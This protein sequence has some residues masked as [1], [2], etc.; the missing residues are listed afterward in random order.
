MPLFDFLVCLE[1]QLINE[2]PHPVFSLLPLKRDI[3]SKPPSTLSE[4]SSTLN[5][6]RRTL[7]CVIAPHPLIILFLAS[8]T[9][10][11]LWLIFKTKIEILKVF[12]KAERI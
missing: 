11:I 12:F 3:L 4:L 10:E 1:I 8:H 6:L 7:I 9:G 2:Y 5:E